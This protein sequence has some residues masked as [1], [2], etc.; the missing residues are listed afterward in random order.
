MTA[1]LS[2]CVRYAKRQNNKIQVMVVLLVLLVMT[3]FT[4]ILLWKPSSKSHCPQNK[5]QHTLTQIKDSFV[6]ITKCHMGP[7]SPQ[8]LIG[9]S[10]KLEEGFKSEQSSSDYNETSN[11]I[12]HNVQTNCSCTIDSNKSCLYAVSQRSWQDLPPHTPHYNRLILRSTPGGTEKTHT[13]LE[14]TGSGG[15]SCT[16]DTKLCT[17]SL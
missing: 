13:N 16:S 9:G 4:Y 15:P 14:K 10:N 12:S 8:S 6:V 17:D 11:K 1:W 2:L 7:V 3:L 5:A